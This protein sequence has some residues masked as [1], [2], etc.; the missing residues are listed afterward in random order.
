MEVSAP[1]II[2]LSLL[3]SKLTVPNPTF[4]PKYP[5]PATE[6]AADGDVV[7]NPTLEFVES[8]V[9]MGMAVDEEVAMEKAFTPVG[10]VVVE[11]DAYI[12]SIPENSKDWFEAPCPERENKAPGVDVPIPILPPPMEAKN[13]P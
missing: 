1:W 5:V 8:K 2:N 11:D 3:P 4:P 10:M 7:P 6:K 13:P 9:S 12:I